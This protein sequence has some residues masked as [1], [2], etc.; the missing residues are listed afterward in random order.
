[1][2]KAKEI[3]DLTS[4]SGIILLIVLINCSTLTSFQSVGISAK[5]NGLNPLITTDT[6]RPFDV[7]PKSCTRNSLRYRPLSVSG[8]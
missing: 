1:M 3:N 2:V 6:D 7:T 8:L 5:K 4:Y